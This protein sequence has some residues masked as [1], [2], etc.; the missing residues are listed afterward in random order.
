[1][2]RYERYSLIMA[3]WN[4]IEPFKIAVF[5]ECMIEHR[6]DDFSEDGFQFSGDTFNT[7][8][9]LTRLLAEKK[10]EL[11]YIT[12]LG[13]DERSSQMISAWQAVNVN[14]NYVR[15]LENKL[16]GEYTIITDDRGERSFTYNRD[17]SAAKEVLGDDYHITLANELREMDLFYL[18]GISVA[19]LV[20]ADRE[21]LITLLASLRK[22]GVIL[23]FD[24]N[25]RA[26][27]W[28]SGKQ[29][30]EW[31]MKLY[32][33]IDVAL[34]S[35]DDERFVFDDNT[36]HD[37]CERLAGFHINEIVVKN[38]GLPCTV[39]SEGKLSTYPVTQQEKITD[40]TAAGDSFNAGYISARLC[41]HGVQSSIKVGCSLADI[42]I[43]HPGAI[44]PQK[45][46]PGV[47]EL[48]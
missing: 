25:Y 46:M 15:R 47:S 12:A 16:P 35:F 45:L 24:S 3:M 34:L 2:T 17:K 27:L 8:I 43:R 41:G 29:A 6:H 33:F 38:A 4:N 11:Y 48:L 28:Q 36:P 13:T 9:Y 32:P 10:A 21:K 30:R 19:I 44:I 5:G 37:T 40:T 39:M 18:S 20:P 14:T 26:T 1:M 42:V 22:A 23:V 7:A 31:C